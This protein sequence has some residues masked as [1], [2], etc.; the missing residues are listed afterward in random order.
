MPLIMASAIIYLLTL[1]VLC[2]LLWEAND[3][4]NLKQELMMVVGT[5]LPIFI[6]W[7]L[8]TITDIFPANFLGTYVYGMLV[9]VTSIASLCICNFLLQTKAVFH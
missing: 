1:I 6:I 4:I 2:Y 8:K 9:I 3:A 5:C 7:A